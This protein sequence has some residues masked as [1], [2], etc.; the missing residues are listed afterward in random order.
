MSLDFSQIP[1]CGREKELDIL[2][3]AANNS[4]VVFV[5]A[6]PGT[7]KT[8]LINTFRSRFKNAGDVFFCQ[9]AYCEN[10]VEP[11]AFMK[12]CLWDVMSQWQPE[13]RRK[14]RDLLDE[15]TLTEIE[16]M[17]WIV[18]ELWEKISQKQ[19]KCHPSSLTISTKQSSGS[20]SQSEGSSDILNSIDSPSA[21]SSGL[22][23][24]R[25]GLSIKTFV[26]LLT[27]IRRLIVLEDDMQWMPDRAVPQ[28]IDICLDKQL[29]DNITIVAIHR[30][31]P[32]TKLRMADIKKHVPAHRLVS[33]PLQ[34]LSIRGVEEL[35]SKISRREQDDLDVTK[36]SQVV[37]ERTHGNPFYGIQLLAQMIRKEGITLD[38]TNLKWKI[39]IDLILE[40][41]DV[42]DNVVDLVV[43]KISALEGKAQETLSV[44][45]CL[46]VQSMDASVI[47]GAMH[48]HLP[49]TEEEQLLKDTNIYL[50]MLCAEGLLLEIRDKEAYKFAHHRVLSAASSLLPTN[51]NGMHE[52]FGKNLRTHAKSNNSATESSFSIDQVLLLSMDHL[53]RC[54]YTFCEREEVLDLATFGIEV[55][56]I[57][58]NSF[59]FHTALIFLQTSRDWL[60]RCR[61]W[62]RNYDLLLK[63]TTELAITAY[64]LGDLQLCQ[65]M[66]K[67]V[68]SHSKSLDDRLPI[69]KTLAFALLQSGS[70]AEAHDLCVSVVTDLGV[71]FPTR[72]ILPKSVL[73]VLKLL[74]RCSK[75]PDSFFE[76]LQL[77]QDTKI[78]HAYDLLEVINYITLSSKRNDFLFASTAA[79]GNILYEHGEVLGKG[80]LPNLLGFFS[81][82]LRKQNEAARYVRLA[83]KRMG[84]IPDHSRD[85][86]VLWLVNRTFVDH[87][88]FS[89]KEALPPLVSAHRVLLKTGESS[90]LGTCMSVY[91]VISFQSGLSLE[92]VEA[93]GL[94]TNEILTILGLCYSKR[95]FL[96]I[97]Q[98]F[99]N[100]RGDSMDPL[101]LNG[102]VMNSRNFLGEDME[103][104]SI[105]S[106]DKHIHMY[107]FA[108]L[109]LSV[110]F[111]NSNTALRAARHMLSKEDEGIVAW[112]PFRVFLDSM[113]HLMAA[114]TK[115]GVKRHKH[116][117]HAKAH[118]RWLV[119]QRKQGNPN[120]FHYIALCQAEL[121]SLKCND[122][123]K[124][125]AS[126]DE[127]IRM[128]ASIG[129]LYCKALASESAA[130][131]F[132]S[133][134]EYYWFETY[135]QKAFTDY[136]DWGAMAKV[137][138]LLELYPRLLRDDAAH[139]GIPAAVTQRASS[140]PGENGVPISPSEVLT[141]SSVTLGSSLGRSLP[142]SSPSAGGGHSSLQQLDQLE[143]NS[144]S[145]GF[146]S[147][148]SSEGGIYAKSQFQ[149]SS[150][151]EMKCSLRGP[152][153]K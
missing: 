98:M 58:R 81:I 107:H 89:L 48:G 42:T 13:D 72:M 94:R 138:Q 141:A 131:Y 26:R 137:N 83:R 17:R 106:K 102:R 123:D 126:F 31:D 105:H 133:K 18:P 70:V 78:R 119:R 69:L 24:E 93:D 125:R 136:M 21:P 43:E 108:M 23:L 74:R 22:A 40:E 95:L 101:S 55:A 1:I 113:A 45:A 88:Q 132:L 75:K 8:S 16:P 64:S 139:S 7:G 152:T 153:I 91:S 41:A 37:H 29:Q 149:N 47:A 77:C 52:R 111:G 151:Q 27:K 36:L 32:S 109:I 124:V 25:L 85:S 147:K 140:R 15:S 79:M 122:L 99:L 90:M 62:S 5:S 54:A 114:K 63:C 145:S 117:V 135:L 3:R 144:S 97:L 68:V 56:E 61:G 110:I 82:V 104:Q 121:L 14:L 6:G 51:K 84:D 103:S 53:S 44:A 143:V 96:P 118:L 60:M 87:W 129:V 4:S 80:E 115:R 30:D 142:F 12:S 59:A 130:K 50:K 127:A 92:Y 65:T 19:D 116:I 100:L 73:K 20:I 76:N 35:I 33:L 57:A 11:F 10:D 150:L 146:F 112:T 120:C 67:E 128:A 86:S 34:N 28:F 148:R 2:E 49:S 9:G 46:G 71:D 66:A 39:N 134:G 38:L